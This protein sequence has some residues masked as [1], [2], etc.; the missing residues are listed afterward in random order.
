MYVYRKT[1]QQLWTVGFYD[2]S[3]TWIPESDWGS[4]DD[5]AYLRGIKLRLNFIA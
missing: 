2:P 5:A 3:C 4:K 1:E